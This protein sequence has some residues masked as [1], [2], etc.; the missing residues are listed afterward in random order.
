MPNL[1]FNFSGFD[2][3]QSQPAPMLGQHNVEIA[4]EM[5]FSEAEIVSMQKDGVLYSEKI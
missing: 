2:I 1:P 3:D 4:S 5:G